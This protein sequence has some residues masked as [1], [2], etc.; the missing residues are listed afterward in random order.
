LGKVPSGQAEH[1]VSSSGFRICFDQNTKNNHLKIVVESLL[2]MAQWF[3]FFSFFYLKSI[4][5]HVGDRMKEQQIQRV[6]P[7]DG[8]TAK[9][10]GFLSVPVGHETAT[11]EH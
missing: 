5:P 2:Q 1:C 7:F 4:D 6:G 9:S 11:R 3:P 8:E 10:W